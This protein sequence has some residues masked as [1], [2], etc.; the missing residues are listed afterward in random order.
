VIVPNLES[1][2]ATQNVRLLRSLTENTDGQFLQLTGI[3]TSLPALLPDRSEPVIIEEQ[4]HTLWDRAWMMYLM[5]FL[6]G[7]EWSIRRFVRLS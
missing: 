4:L 2:D 7:L 6:L 5:I 3:S 1:L